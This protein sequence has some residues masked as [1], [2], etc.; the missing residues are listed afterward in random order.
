[1]TLEPRVYTFKEI[2]DQAG[3]V[4][5]DTYDRRRIKVGG[6]GFDSI[7]ETFKVP[8]AA[9]ELELTLDGEVYAPFP[10]G[11]TGQ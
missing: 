6:L 8:E 5:D 9:N 11:E 4:V 3:L 7:D 1:M 10:V 2:L